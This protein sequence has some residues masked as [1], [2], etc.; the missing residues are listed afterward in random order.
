MKIVKKIM[1][2]FLLLLGKMSHLNPAEAVDRTVTVVCADGSVSGISMALL[3]DNFEYFKI[4]FN[5]RLQRAQ[6]GVR[7]DCSVEDFNDLLFNMNNQ[8]FFETIS[9]EKIRSLAILADF[10]C[11]KKDKFVFL[12]KSFEQSDEAQENF[13]SGD[14]FLYN[15]F[16]NDGIDR[17]AVFPIRIQKEALADKLEAI[18]LDG[19]YGVRAN[20]AMFEVCKIIKRRSF[21]ELKVIF[22]IPRVI[23]FHSEVLF[24]LDSTLICVGGEKTPLQLWDISSHT[25]VVQSKE[26]LKP[27]EFSPDGKWLLVERKKYQRDSWL[28]RR[29][30]SSG[31]DIYYSS[32]CLYSV[33]EKKIETVF[34]NTEKDMRW[35]HFSNDSRFL[36]WFL[37]SSNHQ[38]K[39]L[40]L[41]LVS[42]KE[43]F[44]TAPGHFQTIKFSPD[45]RKI[46]V[47]S[48]TRGAYRI[49]SSDT[50]VFDLE[51]K[52]RILDRGDLSN[53]H[54]TADSSQ[55]VFT[56]DEGRP[57]FFFYNTDTR[58]HISPR[59]EGKIRQ[60][61]YDGEK[62]IFTDRNAVQY[63]LINLFSKD[64]HISLGFNFCRLKFSDDGSKVLASK[65]EGAVEVFDSITG[66]L[67]YELQEGFSLSRL[68]KFRKFSSEGNFLI[69]QQYCDGE[70]I[71]HLP[72]EASPKHK[73]LF[74]ALQSKNDGKLERLHAPQEIEDLFDQ[75]PNELKEQLL[76]KQG[77]LERTV[78]KAIERFSRGIARIRAQ[79]KMAPE[80]EQPEVEVA[81][82]L[83]DAIP[84]HEQMD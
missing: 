27:F 44:K 24:S 41:D 72:F 74:E 53:F 64:K 56:F 16:F 47:T 35:R 28:G 83:D 62:F 32:V 12:K 10:L 37:D 40:V 66:Q 20:G 14:T 1:V 54:F 60:A 8:Q 3:I 76:T 15:F 71:I 6:I 46:C 38:N 49:G 17:P 33:V 51:S 68:D 22:T 25:L 2:L 75:L 34:P 67:L 18:S 43:H 69:L 29:F 79:Q 81:A 78:A 50:Q 63:S 61:S 57:Y 42:R 55:Y 5:T 80:Q 36:A 65:E 19:H 59:I 58:Q 11:M 7:I 48:C 31:P 21:H 73:Y 70:T 39:M 77:L 45:S 84:W 52:E 82:S 30:A 26:C 4:L 13:L 9:F 23:C